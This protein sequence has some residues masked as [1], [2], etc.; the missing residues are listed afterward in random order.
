MVQNWFFVICVAMD[1]TSCLLI[2]T[3]AQIFGST[4]VMVCRFFQGLA[5]GGIAPLLHML[6]GKWAP[7][8]E[9]SVMATLSYSGTLFCFGS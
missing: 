7:P 8:C 3:V 9:R 2:P 1:S 4:G 5:Q 6:L